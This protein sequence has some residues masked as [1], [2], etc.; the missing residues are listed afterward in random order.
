MNN[1]NEIQ[2][3]ISNV[4]EPEIAEVIEPAACFVTE[5]LI[6]VT[7]SIDDVLDAVSRAYYDGEDIA[8]HMG[9]KK[10]M[11]E[12]AHKMLCVD[13]VASMRNAQLEFP[14]YP[15]ENMIINR[16]NDNDGNFRMIVQRL[17]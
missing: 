3:N 4:N 2:N 11:L 9:A 16:R 5:N 17:K 14:E 6:G 7:D 1:Y 15:T 8:F 10:E 12:L 13:A